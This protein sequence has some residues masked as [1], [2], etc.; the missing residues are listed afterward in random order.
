MDRIEEW[1]IFASVAAHGGFAA[2]ARA[3][4]CSP[5]A[6]TRAV[7]ALESRL[8]TRLINRTT[9][10]I[11]LTIEGRRYLELAQRLI[12]SFDQLERPVD[13][14]G[15]LRGSLSVTAPILFGQQYVV[16]VLRDFL[17]AQPHVDARVQLSDSVLSLAEH[18]IDVGVRI[19]PLRGRSLRALLLG[20]VRYVTCASPAYLDRAGEPR[21]PSELEHHSCIAF[22]ATSPRPEQWSFWDSGKRERAVTVRA[23]LVVNTGRAAIDAAL[24]G[25]GVVRVLSYQVDACCKSGSLR[26]LLP[27]YAP[28]PIPVHVVSLTGQR[29]RCVRAFVEYAT[30]R[31]KLHLRALTGASLSG[32][33][34]TDR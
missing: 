4:A 29:S 19:G 31:M 3:H 33:R 16:P 24:A 20:H 22:T 21:T 27:D 30:D 2:A 7:A 11:S 5:Q 10:S 15:E 34:G 26:I 8:G 25:L 6:T 28:A 12:A 14:H 13:Q 23:R 32:Q 1:R 18:A 17:E 9:R